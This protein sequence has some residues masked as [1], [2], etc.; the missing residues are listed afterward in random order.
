M[1]MPLGQD[2]C[3]S[4]VHVAK[5]RRG[6]GLKCR[7]QARSRA[8]SPGE[9]PAGADCQ[10]VSYLCSARPFCQIVSLNV[11][12]AVSNRLVML[13]IIT[14]LGAC[15]PPISAVDTQ[16]LVQ[17]AVGRTAALRSAHFQLDVT[18]GAMRIGPSLE[19]TK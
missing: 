2:V 19:V 3:R 17:R 14:L 9:A 18:K 6:V 13:A 5:G 11:V 4:G 10:I 12:G 15:S 7:P 1:T 16:A 8:S